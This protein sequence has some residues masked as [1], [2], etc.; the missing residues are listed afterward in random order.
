[1]NYTEDGPV[2]DGGESYRS[3]LTS[4]W[5]LKGLKAMADSRQVAVSLTPH[6][7]IVVLNNSLITHGYSG[8]KELYTACSSAVAGS[9]RKSVVSN[10]LGGSTLPVASAAP[11]AADGQKVSTFR[12][13]Q[14]VA[15]N[16]TVDGQPGVTAIDAGFAVFGWRVRLA[17]SV[18][19]FSFTPLRID[20]GLPSITGGG[21]AP[22]TN[23]NVAPATLTAANTVLS[24]IVFPRRTP[25]DLLI[26]SVGNAGGVA[27]VV[28][29][30]CDQVVAYSA[31]ATTAT[32]NHCIVNSDYA[33]QNAS[34][35]ATIESLNSRDLIARSP[36][37]KEGGPIIGSRRRRSRRDEETGY[38][39]GIF[40]GAR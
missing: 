22:T 14:S 21:A 3:G 12:S 18:T 28:P 35:F 37:P 38:D 2:Y 30:L 15:G 33:V 16:T 23:Q 31:T 34:M 19:N 8:L 10:D 1:M 6:A 5:L 7:E 25:V 36:A 4:S 29:G 11:I 17:G 24:L 32:Q 26:L 13:V 9:F 27:T 39:Q 20:V 40:Y